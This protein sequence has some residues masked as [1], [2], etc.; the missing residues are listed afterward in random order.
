MMVEPPLPTSIVSGGGNGAD[1]EH[2]MV[3]AQGLAAALVSVLSLA[4]TVAR[5]TSG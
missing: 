2:P 3:V 1:L 4:A 5:V